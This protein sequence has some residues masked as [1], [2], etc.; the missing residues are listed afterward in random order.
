MSL[1]LCPPGICSGWCSE[2]LLKCIQKGCKRA[3]S[4]HSLACAHPRQVLNVC[5]ANKANTMQ[6]LQP[7]M[8]K[9]YLNINDER[10]LDTSDFPAPLNSVPLPPMMVFERGMYLIVWCN[11]VAFAGTVI[12]WQSI[13]VVP[14][15]AC[16]L[17]VSTG[18]RAA[19]PCRR[20]AG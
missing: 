5:E 4:V 17:L 10:D 13:R 14:A 1:M 12:A 7:L 19:V 9:L 8:P 3:G 6:E 18:L 15:R 11:C 16:E 20:G 2:T